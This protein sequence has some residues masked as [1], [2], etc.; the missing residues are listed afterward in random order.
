VNLKIAP[1]QSELIQ[2]PM[3]EALFETTGTFE[4]HLVWETFSQK[5]QVV[6]L[7]D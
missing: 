5:Q 6:V 2:W 1:H 3:G 4:L 7:N